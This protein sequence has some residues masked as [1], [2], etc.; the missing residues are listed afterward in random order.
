MPSRHA[1]HG[2]QIYQSCI[3]KIVRSAGC[4]AKITRLAGQF[5]G[6]DEVVNCAPVIDQIGGRPERIHVISTQISATPLNYILAYIPRGPVMTGLT[7]RSRESFACRKPMRV[8]PATYLLERI[9]D[10]ACHI[11]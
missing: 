3:K 8:L 5:F 7:Q 11:Q 2:R 6:P 4:Q 9:D 10:L 1:Q